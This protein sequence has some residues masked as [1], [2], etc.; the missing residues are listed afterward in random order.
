MEVTTKQ[1]FRLFRAYC[2]GGM[3]IELK[4]PQSK[5]TLK[6]ALD[7]AEHWAKVQHGLSVK[8]VAVKGLK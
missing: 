4:A 8:V 3:E 2:E 6:T 1:K 7:Y 5:L